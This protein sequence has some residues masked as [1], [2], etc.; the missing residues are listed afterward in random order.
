MREYKSLN[1]FCNKMWY[2]LILGAGEKTYLY[3]SEEWVGEG[4]AIRE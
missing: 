1:G 2:L 4:K 3:L